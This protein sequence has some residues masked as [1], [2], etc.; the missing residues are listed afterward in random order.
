MEPGGGASYPAMS[1]GER[2]PFSRE[3]VDS[4]GSGIAESRLDPA[5]RLG[6]VTPAKAEELRS[7]IVDG[8]G[9]EPDEPSLREQIERERAKMFSQD[10]MKPSSRESETIDGEPSLLAQVSYI[11]RMR[12]TGRRPDMGS[13]APRTVLR[14]TQSAALRAR[15]DRSR[16]LS[17]MME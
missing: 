2:M 9:N 15:A 5:D 16:R 8:T 17:D 3:A 6:F 13:P 10:G 12:A 11:R 1:Y 7:L 4:Q 14:T